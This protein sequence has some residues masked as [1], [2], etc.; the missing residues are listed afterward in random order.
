MTA[1]ATPIEVRQLGICLESVRGTVPAGG[2]TKF[3]SLTKDSDINWALKLL[4]D[5]TLRGY[6][7]RGASFPG[8]L[9]GKGPFKTPVRASDAYYWLKMLLGAPTSVE[10]ASF[11]VTTGVNDTLDFNIGA[12]NLVAT[13]AAG[14]YIAGQTQADTGSLCALLFNAIHAAEGAGT[15]TVSFS[16][17]TGLFTITRSA[18]TLVL[19][20][21]DGPNVA[22]SIGPLIGFAAVDQSGALTY[23]GTVV[24]NPPFKHTFTQGQIT[25]LPAYS[26]YINRG[27]V[28]AANNKTKS[29]PIGSVEKLKLSSTNESPIEMEAMVV[30]QQELEYSGSWSPSY[31]ESGVLMFNQ[32]TVK[33]AGSTPAVPNV[34]TWS[35]EY[36]PGL[37]EYRP[38]ST[39]Q[40]PYDILAAGP[41]E[42]SGDAE[43]YFMDEVERNKFL[44]DTLTS[45]EFK[46]VGG[47]IAG[48][49]GGSNN[50]TLDLL[51]SNVEY[52]AFP[53]GESPDGF[54]MAKVKW[55][56]PGIVTGA[57]YAANVVAYVINTVI[58]GS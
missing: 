14:T 18:G 53:F 36:M 49:G 12:S 8:P 20:L 37:K 27:F 33:L 32:T 21:A 30:A 4:S 10:Q 48:G 31:S 3:F 13:V 25:Q 41:F 42:A 35:A 11:T 56:S 17:S 2:P 29:Y 6:N 58:P 40:Y 1:V 45:L 24:Q 52:K 16:R 46:V 26:F 7:S 44:A 43:I 28:D 39:F 54:L 57:S 34:R 5:P 19:D 50:Y 38:L 51:H 23:T 9:S 22:K 15:Y 55:N 47:A